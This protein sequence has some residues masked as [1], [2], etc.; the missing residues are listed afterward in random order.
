M[1][2]PP[3]SDEALW[4]AAEAAKAL[5]A[6]AGSA[7]QASGVSIDS[8]TI[9]PGDLFVAIRG[10][11]ADGHDFAKAAFERGAVAAVVE[12]AIEGCAPER[13]LLVPDTLAGLEALGKA[14]R[15][16]T[17]AKI[18]AVTGSVGKTG[19]K[20]ALKLALARQAKTTASLASLNNLWGVPLSLA[21][22]PRD[23]AYGIFELG[24]NHP[25]EL[26]PLSRLVRPHVAIVTTV[27][28]AHSEFFDS[29]IDIADAKAEIFQGMEGGVAVLNRDNALYPILAMA[30]RAAG[31]ERIIGFGAHNEAD[32]RLISYSSRQGSSE[33]TA[34]ILGH[35]LE[36][37]IGAPGRHWALNSLAVLATVAAVGADLPAAAAALADLSAPKGRGELHRVTLTGGSF[38][39]I[40]DS[41]NASPASMRAAIEILSAS[42]PGSGGRRIAILGDMLELGSGSPRLHAALAEPL[43]AG[44]IDLV[45]TAGPLMALLHEA[46][47]PAMRGARAPD[48]ETL[49]PL[50]TAAIRPGDVVVV[51]GSYGSRMGKVVEALLAL[52]RPPRAVNG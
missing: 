42:E 35:M 23:A 29:L 28:T 26:G 39:L 37:R 36:Y 34:R 17:H 19:T 48:A 2:A 27:A 21:R 4:T 11:R 1:S 18:I 6:R 44:R 25:G 8:R 10:P 12:R 40:D 14:A 24:M 9:A 22:M 33:V 47:P 5:G 41:Y 50:A 45:F 20:E 13:L 32:A 46:L 7:W 43:H 38:E 3:Q 49:L 30:A 15:A 16:R 31:V 51:K 52:D